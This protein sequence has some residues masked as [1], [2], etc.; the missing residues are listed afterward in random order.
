EDLWFKHS[1]LQTADLANPTADVD[2][3][4]RTVLDL[5]GAN[6]TNVEM[7]YF[8]ADKDPN[9]RK[10]LIEWLVAGNPE[11]AARW[12]S[13]Q[14]SAERSRRATAKLHEVAT[15]NHFD[16]LLK[17][18]LSRSKSDAQVLEA[19]TLATLAR[20]PTESEQQF[21]IDYVKTQSDRGQA[22]HSVL[23]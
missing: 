20:F 13:M 9:K 15:S 16:R 7:K 10:K 3:L 4:R 22:W 21:V 8:T 14:R 2:F 6:P 1:Q 5:T 17:E 18:L 23:T 19:L 12:E 11:A